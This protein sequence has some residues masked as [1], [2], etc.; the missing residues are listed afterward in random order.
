MTEFCFKRSDCTVY[1]FSLLL[2]SFSFGSK[3][4][5]YLVLVLTQL[6]SSS[7]DDGV[8]NLANSLTLEGP[9]CLRGSSLM[10]CSL[11]Q[12]SE[13]LLFLWRALA[14]SACT[15]FLDPMSLGHLW[16]YGGCGMFA[17]RGAETSLGWF[18]GCMVTCFKMVICCLC[19][20]SQVVHLTSHY[21]IPLLLP[22]TCEQ[23]VE[24]AL[25]L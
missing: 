10:S 15:W 12:V 17:V 5:L 19:S 14:F 3:S 22:C 8:K 2:P 4:L 20:L 23:D 1:F 13:S 11:S 9:M 16:G 7:S 21:S 24:R 25:H 6:C 18:C